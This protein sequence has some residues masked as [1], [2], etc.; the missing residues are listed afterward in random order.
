MSL[1]KNHFFKKSMIGLFASFSVC[2]SRRL[3]LT[4]KYCAVNLGCSWIW[5]D[6]YFDLSKS[7][8]EGST[9][10]VLKDYVLMPLFFMIFY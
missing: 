4:P 9:K 8:L 10:R 7:M 1:K 6:N 3:D 2:C 5:I